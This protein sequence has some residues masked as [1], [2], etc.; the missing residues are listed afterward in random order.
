[1]TRSVLGIVTDVALACC[2]SV[3]VILVARTPLLLRP[4]L[5]RTRPEAAGEDRAPRAPDQAAEPAGRAGEPAGRAG[6]PAGAAGGGLRDEITLPHAVAS[7]RAIRTGQARSSRRAWLW[8]E[9]GLTGELLLTSQQVSVGRATE[10]DVVLRDPTVSREHAA[11]TYANGAWWLLPAIT[12][13]GTWLNDAPVQPGESRVL[14]DGD[15][16][17]FGLRTLVRMFIPPAL[18][19]PELEFAAAARTT[20]G[21]KPAG[22]LEDRDRLKSTADAHLATPQLLVIADGVTD[23]PWP[24]IAARTAVIEVARSPAG[25]PLPELVERVNDSI[26]SIGRNALQL[27]G[28]A[29]TLDVVRLFRD[30]ARGWCLE[31]AHVGDGQVL[32]QDNLGIHRLTRQNTA[33]GRLADV[34][35]YR[36]AGL[37][38]DP[39]FNRLTAAVGLASGVDAERWWVYAD[40]EQRLVLTTDGLVNALGG[41]R[42]RDVLRNHRS[43]VPDDVADLLIQLAIGARTAHNVT[44]IVADIAIPHD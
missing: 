6:K 21:T 29:A 31:G 23:R 3:A 43:A 1:M 36:A 37:A 33:G 2:L 11:L 25:Q 42:L 7:S 32:L 4:R 40:H 30:A 9:R 24:H 16:L 10:C 13:N 12:S 5:I 38:A 19:E 15:L 20:P 41:E 22:R 14:S 44:V 27:T 18:A 17:Q 39:D 8:G 34:D 26:L 28:M 35:P